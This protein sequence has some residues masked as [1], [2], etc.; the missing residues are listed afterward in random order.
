MSLVKTVDIEANNESQDDIPAA[1]SAVIATPA[2]P[3]GSNDVT[4]F[5]IALSG[6]FAIISGNNT[7][8]QSPTSPHIN[9]I[10]YFKLPYPLS[11]RIN[12]R[13][14]AKR[15]S[16]EIAIQPKHVSRLVARL[17]R[18]EYGIFITTSYFTKQCQEEVINDQYP[19]KLLSGLDVINFLKEY[20]FISENKLNDKFYGVIK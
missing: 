10:G 4:T 17:G 2:A 20:G 1:Y 8:T 18:G 12:I 15:F 3:T 19:I 14:E 9:V 11:Y 13:G 6:F 5:G 7:A 16:P